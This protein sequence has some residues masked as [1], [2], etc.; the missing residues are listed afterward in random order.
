[1]TQIG[2]Y[3]LVDKAYKVCLAI[4]ECG[5][6]EKLTYAV[7]LASELMNDLES[8]TQVLEQITQLIGK[9][10]ETVSNS[11]INRQCKLVSAVEFAK[12]IVE[13]KR[14]VHKEDVDKILKDKQVYFIIIKENEQDC[15]HYIA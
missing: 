5:A 6:S 1:M 9:Y 12:L 4:E 13:G 7:T 8:F 3:P 14:I 15:N 10:V 11:S 2:K